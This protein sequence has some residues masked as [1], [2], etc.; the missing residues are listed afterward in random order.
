M[1][2][3]LKHDDGRASPEERAGA[4]R[5]ELR[6]GKENA[7]YNNPRGQSAAPPWKGGY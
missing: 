1:F 5:I 7:F 3:L 4:A 2:D 6:P